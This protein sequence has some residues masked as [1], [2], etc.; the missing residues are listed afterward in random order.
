MNPAT[1][2]HNNVLLFWTTL[3]ILR[4]LYA[5]YHMYFYFTAWSPSEISARVTLRLECRRW[6]TRGVERWRPGSCRFWNL[7]RQI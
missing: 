7:S 2:F 3:Y 1:T 4:G 6:T 5:L